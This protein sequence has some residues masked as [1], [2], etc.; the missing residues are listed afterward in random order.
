MSKSII[1][2]LKPPTPTHIVTFY[3]F[4]SERSVHSDLVSPSSTG[5]TISGKVI[6]VCVEIIICKSVWKVTIGKYQ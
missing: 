6:E 2:I 3:Q 1:I 5:I 4:G